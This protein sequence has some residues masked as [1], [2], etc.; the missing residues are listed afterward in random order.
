MIPK[1]RTLSKYFD[2]EVEAIK[3]VYDNSLAMFLTSCPEDGYSM[4]KIDEFRFKCKKKNHRRIYTTRKNS[5][6]SNIKIAVSDF[7]L[8]MYL[9]ICEVPI[10]STLVITGHS[11]ETVNRIYKLFRIYIAAEFDNVEIKIGG[12]GVEVQLDECKFGKRK[13]HR[14]HRVEGVWVFGGVE[15][16]EERKMFAV[17]VERKD[18][19]TLNEFILKHVLPGSIVITDGWKGYSDFKRNSNFSHHWVNHSIEF[20]N[21]AGFH[22]N[23]IEGT[24]NGIKMKVK[25]QSRIKRKMQCYLFEFIWRR[26]NR[27]NLWINFLHLLRA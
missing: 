5:I 3:F 20:K 17:I 11:S 8:L 6:L 22:T 26:N 12:P 16:T 1:R 15:V 13:Y 19:Q 25:P 9:F 2:N 7:V 4:K 27:S 21:S 24:W 10:K 23:N 18:S 14:G